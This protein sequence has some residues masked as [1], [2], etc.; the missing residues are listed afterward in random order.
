MRRER[1]TLQANLGELAAPS[2]QRR[3]DH[4]GMRVH[5]ALPRDLASFVHNSVLTDGLQAID[6][7]YAE[8]LSAKIASADVILNVLARRQQSDP[9]SPILTPEHLVLNLPP[10]ADCARY[11]R[12]RGPVAAVGIARDAGGVPARPSGLRSS[13]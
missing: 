11:D 8:L 13:T 7:A 12:L 6:E 2:L 9:V 4:P 1:T 3:P 5:H 10:V